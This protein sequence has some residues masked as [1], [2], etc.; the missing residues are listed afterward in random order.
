MEGPSS[1]RLTS[2]TA[3]RRFVETQ[4]QAQ[5]LRLAALLLQHLASQ[6]ADGEGAGAQRPRGA[7]EVGSATA[8]EI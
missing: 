1:L 7:V 8:T 6:R 3:Q 5:L 4:V 2:T